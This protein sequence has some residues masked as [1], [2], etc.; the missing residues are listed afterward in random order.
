MT[1][2]C[3]GIRT[4]LVCESEA[5]ER[6]REAEANRPVL[7]FVE[8]RENLSRRSIPFQF[9]LACKKCQIKSS[10]I[11]IEWCSK[12]ISLKDMESGRSQSQLSGSDNIRF[13]FD[14]DDRNDDGERTNE[15][16]A[17]I[18]SLFSGALVIEDFID[19]P[20]ERKLLADF[21][22]REWRPSQSGH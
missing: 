14:Q 4:C 1:C 20:L 11:P 22:A 10:Q 15:L 21:E 9:C 2:S 13:C 19:E 7:Q 16:A 18:A 17:S 12:I 3:T 6:E 5:A 8:H